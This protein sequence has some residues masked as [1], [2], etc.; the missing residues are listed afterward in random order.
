MNNESVQEV[1]A[2]YY[3]A[4]VET[5]RGAYVAYV[6]AVLAHYGKS[7][8]FASGDVGGSSVQGCDSSSVDDGG[9]SAGAV[10]CAVSDEGGPGALYGTSESG[11]VGEHCSVGSS[12]EGDDAGGSA[13]AGLAAGGISDISS[14]LCVTDVVKPESDGAHT[15]SEVSDESVVKALSESTSSGSEPGVN[16]QR[17]RL[18]REQKKEAK[19]KLKEQVVERRPSVPPA[20]G[21]L[22]VRSI[23]TGPL[24]PT[25]GGY[26]G[27]Y[28]PH[29]KVH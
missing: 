20:Y 11:S 22:N 16:L 4:L 8:Q 1:R 12:L 14:G 9:R 15:G 13:V 7:A 25:F 24:R 27:A 19:R 17:N 26:N 6:K 2:L 3:S 5:D 21:R 10:V 29:W 23:P 18:W 28:A